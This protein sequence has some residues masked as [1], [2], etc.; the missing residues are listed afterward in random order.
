MNIL[1]LFVASCSDLALRIFN[2]RFELLDTVR[3]TTTV[4]S[5]A[6]NEV[7]SELY[8]GG[9]GE[10]LCEEWEEWVNEWVAV[11]GVGG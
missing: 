1:Q 10:W 9:V 8:T 3:V 11:G 4:L 6:F 2:E 5:L 7:T